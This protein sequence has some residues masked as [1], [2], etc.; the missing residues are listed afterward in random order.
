MNIAFFPEH[1]YRPGVPFVDLSQEE[2]VYKLPG[3][4]KKVYSI[5]NGRQS[6]VQNSRGRV[7]SSVKILTKLHIRLPRSFLQ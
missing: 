6:L 3:T 4:E 5:S 7:F 1:T 2:E